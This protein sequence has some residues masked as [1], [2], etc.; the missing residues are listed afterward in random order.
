MIAVA[1][2]TGR[3]GVIIKILSVIF[4]G[5]QTGALSGISSLGASVPPPTNALLKS[6]GP[7][8]LLEGTWDREAPLKDMLVPWVGI[9]SGKEAKVSRSTSFDEGGD[10]AEEDC[11]C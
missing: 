3:K 8:L 2:I 10:F 9:H 11:M 6:P 4:S 5:Y 1:I 7:S